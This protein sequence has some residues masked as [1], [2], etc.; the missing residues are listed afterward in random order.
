MVW[1][2]VKTSQWF[3]CNTG[4]HR[5]FPPTPWWLASLLLFTGINNGLG[6][7]LLISPGPF[8]TPWNLVFSAATEGLYSSLLNKY[9]SRASFVMTSLC[10][11]S[12]LPVCVCICLLVL[13]V[14][15]PSLFLFRVTFSSLFFSFAFSF[16]FSFIKSVSSLVSLFS[17]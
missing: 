15:V 14:S 9:L 7:L 6:L 12:D 11:T 13:V 2:Y 8:C 10:W 3:R 5:I 1:L 17:P 16:S 4:T